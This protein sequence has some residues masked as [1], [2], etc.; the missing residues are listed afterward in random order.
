MQ[1]HGIGK[2][3]VTIKDVAAKPPCRK[4]N[5]HARENQWNYALCLSLFARRHSFPREQCGPLDEP[6]E[7]FFADVK[8][9]AIRRRE[10]GEGLI[11]HFQTPEPYDSQVL[12]A[13]LPDLILFQ[14]HQGG[15]RTN[16][17]F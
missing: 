5:I 8:M 10:I 6:A 1:R 9:F 2:G 16:P 17:F 13:C 15:M 4:R 12:A 14:F 3:A 7:C 11:L